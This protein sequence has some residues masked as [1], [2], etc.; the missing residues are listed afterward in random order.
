MKQTIDIIIEEGHHYTAG[1]E[2]T[3]VDAS[4]STYGSVSPC[5]NE[6]EISN[7]II[8]AKEMILRENDQWKIV[9]KREKALLTN[10]IGT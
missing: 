5:N 9:D 1:G 7:A 8:N 3:S 2:F 10:W 4:A 6:K